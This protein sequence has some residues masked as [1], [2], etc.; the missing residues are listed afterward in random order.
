LFHSVTAYKINALLMT[1][2]WP[3]Q[4]MATKSCRHASVN[5]ASFVKIASKE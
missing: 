4:E 3:E 1:R 5:A 2:V